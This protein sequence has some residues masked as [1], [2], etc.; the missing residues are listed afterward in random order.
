MT[1][2][3]GLDLEIFE[4]Q[5][6]L[7]TRLAE[8]VSARVLNQRTGKT[9]EFY[10]LDF[11]DW[12]NIVAITAAEEIILIRQF[13]FGSRRVELE[14]PGGAVEAGE[15][16]LLAGQRELFE[17]TGYSG[18]GA[19]IIGKV[20]PNPAIQNNICSTVLV[21]DV[22]VTGVQRMDDMEDIEV[23]VLPLEQVNDLISTGR[24]SHGLVLNA[25]MFY[26]MS[27]R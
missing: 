2:R 27:R 9:S 26:T 10:R 17:E 7:S 12:V 24:I 20:N 19:R 25:L 14:I 11:S 15:S 18:K 3:T 16:P 8:V 5:T 6:L 1:K 13:R 4:E 22:I 23:I 21:E